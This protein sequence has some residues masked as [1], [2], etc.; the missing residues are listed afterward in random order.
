MKA[1]SPV[2]AGLKR[3]TPTSPASPSET[4]DVQPK[5]L[6]LEDDHPVE[7]TT[8]STS[9]PDRQP[10]SSRGG[11]GRGGGGRGGH[12]HSGHNAGRPVLKRT[13]KAGA[14][15]Q[16]AA[17]FENVTGILDDMYD[18]R[19]RIIKTS[20]DITIGSKRMIFLLHRITTTADTASLFTE[21]HAKLADLQHLFAIVLPDLHGPDFWK[22][23][24][25]IQPGLEEFIEAVSFLWFLEK[26]RL[27]TKEEV[28][29]CVGIGQGDANVEGGAATETIGDKE[30]RVLVTNEDYV[31]GLGDL[32]G[33]L[34]RHCINLITR[35]DHVGAQTICTFMRNFAAEYEAIS[36]DFSPA[37]KK[38]PAMVASLRKVENACYTVKVRG[39]E[40]PPDRLAE[41]LMSLDHSGARDE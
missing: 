14:D 10:Y 37:R 4:A 5:K 9:N 41:F 20:R 24:R 13:M 17:L 26:G 31:M 23:H 34:M 2:T 36:A 30:K 8:S 1:S 15:P 39:A 18:R 35:G 19:E 27:V 38:V 7:S 32:T 33:E 3:E 6:K 25:A 21:A 29:E 28:Q 40:Y 12:G 11:R 22:H 16:I